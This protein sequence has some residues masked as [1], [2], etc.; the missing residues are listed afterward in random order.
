MADAHSRYTGEATLLV[1]DVPKIAYSLV[2]AG[3][4]LDYTGLPHVVHRAC[5]SYARDIARG[6]RW[7]SAP[8]ESHAFLTANRGR[9][10]VEKRRIGRSEELTV[11]YCPPEPVRGG[12]HAG[13]SY[14]CLEEIVYERMQH[15]D[16]LVVAGFRPQY[17]KMM[18]CFLAEDKSFRAFVLDGKNSWPNFRHSRLGRVDLHEVVPVFSQLILPPR[19]DLIPA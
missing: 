16:T 3:V 12:Q 2:G 7:M 15:F 10:R 8:T 4:A 18:K 1:M 17:A 19:A 11:H 9:T 14:I 6:S 13:F 5:T